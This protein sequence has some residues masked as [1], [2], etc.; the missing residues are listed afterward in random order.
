MKT[1]ALGRNQACDFLNVPKPFLKSVE[2][3]DVNV[4]V[5]VA[6][7]C[8]LLMLALRAACWMGVCFWTI[9]DWGKTVCG[10]MGAREAMQKRSHLGLLPLP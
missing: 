1:Y 3:V 7:W 6:T 10:E 2:D 9:P 4:D 8:A 5:I